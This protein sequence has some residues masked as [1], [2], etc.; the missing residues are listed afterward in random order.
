MFG[1][2][3]SLCIGCHVGLLDLVYAPI[4]NVKYWATH[5][6][7]VV[8]HLPRYTTLMIAWWFLFAKIRN[9]V[10]ALMDVNS[11]LPTNLE[12]QKLRNALYGYNIDMA[13]CLRLSRTTIASQHTINQP[14]NS[15]DSYVQIWLAALSIWYVCLGYYRPIIIT[16]SLQ[17][18]SYGCTVNMATWPWFAQAATTQPNHIDTGHIIF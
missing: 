8:I 2:K 5:Q 17:N 11:M 3:V 16:W 4:K 14:S 9:T 6:W 1:W 15:P 7:H 13:T 10:G 12:H 18:T